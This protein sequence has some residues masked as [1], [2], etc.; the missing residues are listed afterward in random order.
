MPVFAHAQEVLR[1]S[2]AAG[3]APCAVVEV[4]NRRGPLWEAAAGRLT[5]ATGSPPATADTVFDLAS[6]TKVLSTTS[7]AMRLVE[8]GRPSLDARVSALVPGWQGEDRAAVTVH[9]LLAHSSGLPA[10]RPYFER[11]RGRREFE[12]AISDEPLD[13]PPGTASVYSDL[14]FI[15]LGFALE[16]A[17]GRPLDALWRSLADEVWPSLPVRYRLPAEWLVRAAPTSAV[18]ARRGIV[19]DENAAALGGVAGHAG[20]FGT[21]GG[22]GR[23]ARSV[24]CARL[25]ESGPLASPTLVARFTARAGVPGSSRALGWDT[26][27]PS[28]S[29]GT[30]M[31]ADAFGHTGFTGTSLWIDPTKDCYVVL[32]SNRVY[33]AAGD[34]DRI[35][36]FRRALHDAVAE[37]LVDFPT[38][39]TDR[40]SLG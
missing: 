29:C 25:G 23:I 8:T 36:T 1:A 33:P 24:L 16:E 37:D 40:A 39:G 4:G 38:G 5:G 15:L 13:Y 34:A 3:V 30:R 9:D 21:A 28:S 10:H 26:A 19:H 35:R 31:S 27:L 17:A 2:V 7:I 14:G 11:Y 12:R 18:R 6:L 32:L 20:L 22:V